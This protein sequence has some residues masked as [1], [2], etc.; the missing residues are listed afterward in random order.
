MVWMG[1]IKGR[2]KARRQLC[3]GGMLRSLDSL[4]R[5]FV[6][7]VGSATGRHGCSSVSTKAGQLTALE[8]ISSALRASLTRVRRA[9]TQHGILPSHCSVLERR[10]SWQER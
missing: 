8:L 6:V 1:A 5:W 7:D 3:R 2:K 9:R 10:A 4:N